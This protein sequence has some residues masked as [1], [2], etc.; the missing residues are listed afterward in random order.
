MSIFNRTHA[1]L[2]PPRTTACDEALDTC[3]KLGVDINPDHAEALTDADLVRLAYREGVRATEHRLMGS[4]TAD[5]IAFALEYPEE[6][7]AND[8]GSGWKVRAVQQA[9]VYGV[10]K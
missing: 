4:D 2:V 8:R 5:A 6:I 3:I 1:P 7:F 10:P 9:A